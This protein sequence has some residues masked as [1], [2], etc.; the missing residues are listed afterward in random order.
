MGILDDEIGCRATCTIDQRSVQRIGTFHLCRN[1]ESALADR[2][3]QSFEK[4]LEIHRERLVRSLARVRCQAHVTGCL[5]VADIKLQAR[6]ELLRQ[7]RALF[8]GGVSLR[9][10]VDDH[11]N[12]VDLVHELC[13]SIA[14][15][16]V[17]AQLCS[18][19]DRTA[20]PRQVVSDRGHLVGI[21]TVDE[22]NE[23]R[24]DVESMRRRQG[25]H[26][27]H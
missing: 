27:A 3:G 14:Q 26:L 6:A 17:V 10:R 24:I 20:Q 23:V 21:E 19:P 8:D 4:R 7:Q 11:Q 2:P 9:R 22:A 18:I 13:L 1:V 5:G 12:V 25:A 15:L 16:A